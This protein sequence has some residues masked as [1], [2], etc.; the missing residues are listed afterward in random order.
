MNNFSYGISS[1]QEGKVWVTLACE[2]DMEYLEGL[3]LQFLAEDGIKHHIGQEVETAG[4]KT[5]DMLQ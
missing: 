5:R 1:A 3:S 2:Y 4:W